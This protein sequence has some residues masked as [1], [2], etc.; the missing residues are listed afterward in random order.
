M[1]LN[2]W[3]RFLASFPRASALPLTAISL[4]G[5]AADQASSATLTWDVTPG[6]V[7]AG[8]G[9]ITGG[10]GIWS[11][12][13]GIGN[14]TVNGGTNNIAWVNNATPDGAV[15]GG[16]GGLVT[17]IDVTA[18]NIT[19][20]SAG[21]S[22]TGN[23][24]TLAGTT[25]KIT[26]AADATITSVIAGTAGFT[27]DGSARLTLSGVNT[28]SGTIAT[29]AGRLLVSS[30]LRNIGSLSVGT[31]ATLEIG[32]TNIFVAGHGAIVPATMVLTANGGTLLMNT[33][34]DT[35]FGNVT[36][37]NG[38]TWTSDRT[39][40]AYDGLLA[41]TSAGPATVL[42]GGSGTATMNGSGGIHLQGVQNFSV[43]DTSGSTGPDLNVNMILAGPGTTGGAPGGIN[44]TG[45]GTMVLNGTNTYTGATL[46]NGGILRIGASGSIG[47][48]DVTVNGGTLQTEITEK[49][50]SSLTA[51]GGSILMLAAKKNESTRVTGTFA[52]SGAV[53]IKPV[54][55]DSPAAGDSYDLVSSNAF[56]DGGTYTLD[57]NSQGLTRVTG[58]LS[59]DLG[60]Y[61]VLTIGT[62]AA[63]LTWNNA[64]AN[65][66]WDLNTSANFN[67]AGPNDVF[68]TY[69]AVTFGNTGAG[70]VTLA[71][72]LNPGLITVN[73]SAGNYT[74]TGS[75]SLGGSLVKSGSATLNIATTLNL[76]STTVSG[77]T[78]NMT[79]AG[80]LGSG[81]LT[82]NGGTFNNGAGGP[83]T[84]ANAL[85]VDTAATFAGGDLSFSS[86]LTVPG[87][88]DV[89]V[90]GNLSIGGAINGSGPLVK[91]GAG[92]LN[93][94]GNV[95]GSLNALDVSAGTVALATGTAA[96]TANIGGGPDLATLTID[97]SQNLNRLAALA[98]VT[99]GSNGTM[100]LNG[101]NAL[102]SHANSVNVTVAAGGTLSVVSGGSTAITPTGS[103][104]NH[105]G[106][107]T[108]NG[109]TVTL[110]YSGAG[111][112]Y[113][114]ESFQ[115]NRDL[116]VGGS[117]PSTIQFGAGALTGNSGIALSTTVSHTFTVPDVTGSPAA[118]LVV[119]AELENGDAA[120]GAVTKTGAGTMFLGGDFVHSYTGSTT[121]TA[122]TLAATGSIT[123]PL[124]VESG[125]TIAPGA[126]ADTFGAGATT[127]AG[128]YACEIDG[129]FSDK[130]EVTGNVTLSPGAQ[131]VFTTLAGGVT[132]PVYQILTS[133]GSITGPLPATVGAPPGYS[134]SIVS[135]ST[136]VLSQ[137]NVPVQ[138]P[139]L[140]LLPSPA[141]G[142]TQDFEAGT[143]GFSGSPAASP[144]TTWQY[145]AGSWRSNAQADGGFGDVNTSYLGSPVYTIAQAG[146][147]TLT[148][149][150]RHSFEQGF[151][152]GGA[153]EVSKNGAPFTKVESVSFSQ[154]PYN[155]TVLENSTAIL[156]GQLAF[157]QDS[158]GHPGF[159]TSIA[160][161]G[162]AV[163]GD[164]F[165]VRFV[166]ASD[167]NTSGS[168]TPQGW[169]IDSVQ[170]SGGYPSL[171]TLTWGLGT[172]QYSDNLQPPWT[173]IVGSSPLV[174]DTKLAPKRFFRLKP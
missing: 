97:G 38:A 166:S 66:I 140:S 128:T 1:K 17:L 153:V 146:A 59:S 169:Q 117:T 168:L 75:G 156:H 163:A 145:T 125:G 76:A 123:G 171:G 32:A 16:T 18:N 162:N 141:P 138:Q 28:L 124:L 133:T 113:S 74:F 118:D 69:D 104:H 135:G 134:L 44:K 30:S 58:S 122:G 160:T 13:A 148:F 105:I 89:A 46:V 111:T 90:P 167:E 67:N 150:H 78:L 151:Y 107:L 21:Y 99:I 109:G 27:K 7:G 2:R 12:T 71:G 35:R 54:F 91:K 164:R 47:S 80:N 37:N 63:N 42:V 50:M 8:D 25:P 119:N 9:A 95:N 86:G 3:N 121:V 115:L 29:T 61:L 143:G 11:A 48:S 173:D 55:S 43:A 81:L 22:V 5:L 83:L 10:A 39:L 70:T 127:L 103:S 94:N 137:D 159:I 93:L 106:T 49:G 144:Q 147:V 116:T 15:F 108:L 45:A 154:N 4:I 170:I 110:P 174:I 68:M 102:P 142:A 155:G 53:T 158:A 165:Q 51:N 161:L 31:G 26:A 131:L 62:G 40:G 79:S 114:S 96:S 41:D 52:T 132:A 34:T 129:N 84:L 85:V 6:L 14:W 20:N 64:T 139:L 73:S 101:V 36:L 72:Q 60:Q 152:D 172:M 136:L 82:V 24:L 57:L 33:A 157:V 23:T 126:S 92:I 149:S 77:G 120:G 88:T 19:F 112:A 65:G 130:I 100:I 98:E 56:T 87:P